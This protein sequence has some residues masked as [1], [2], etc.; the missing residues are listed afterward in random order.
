MSHKSILKYLLPIFAAIMLF[1][2]GAYAQKT[3][4]SQK[5]EKDIVIAVYDQIKVKY[6]N[7]IR[8]IN[9]LYED[10]VITLNGWVGTKTVSKDIEKLVKK[11]EC[12]KKV[13]NKLKLGKSGGCGPGQKE[14]G[15]LCVGEKDACN[16][17]LADP[18]APG[19][20]TSQEQKKP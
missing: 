16:V 18:L 4:C 9:V 8:N 6:A 19:C 13:V 1:N 3:D 14:C 7:Q 12:V 2:L 20:Y 15:G 10:G 5:T 17:C 11:T